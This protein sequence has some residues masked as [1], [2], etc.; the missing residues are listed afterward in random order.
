MLFHEGYHPEDFQVNH[1]NPIWLLQDNILCETD[2]A[3]KA[4]LESRDIEH[5]RFS[6]YTNLIE[7]L[8]KL[9]KQSLVIPRCSVNFYQRIFDLCSRYY[10]FHCYPFETID[11]YDC[12]NYYPNL[13]K[14]LLNSDYSILPFGDLKRQSAKLFSIHRR[15]VNGL[16]SVFIRPVSGNKCFT[17][18]L[19]D[20]KLVPH[21]DSMFKCE[22]HELVIVASP[23][24]ISDE[25][26]LVIVDSKV[27]AASS[28]SCENDERYELDAESHNSDT[29]IQ[30][31]ITAY[32][33]M[34]FGGVD[35]YNHIPYVMD[36]C[37]E[38]CGRFGGIIE[39]Q[40]IVEINSFNC[41]GLYK[42]NVDSVVEAIQKHAAKYWS[43][44]YE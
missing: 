17:G 1:M 35:R 11:W 16:D 22:P 9:P 7:V 36:I 24:R 18:Q 31:F 30:E 19:I 27:V 20:E 13:G 14:Y 44:L 12:S 40:R 2:D 32:Q 41:S 21:L 23:K 15:Q 25:K 42:C 8:D 28:Y 5:Y 3:F 39:V 34:K 4:A 10:D 6:N 38:E 29:D 37:I 43:E 33:H 26:R